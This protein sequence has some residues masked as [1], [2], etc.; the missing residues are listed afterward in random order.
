MAIVVGLTGGVGSGKTTVADL[1]QSRGAGVVDTDDISRRLT[2]AGQPA[3]KE[4]AH[5]FGAQFVTQDGAL[6]RGRMRRH[7]FADTVARRDLEAILHPLIR[8]E[9]TRQIEENHAPYVLLVVPLLIES[10]AYRDRVRR[11]LVVD[12]EVETQIRRVMAR[13]SLTR[14]EVMAIIDAQA[15]RQQRLAAADDVI[16]NDGSPDRLPPQVDKLHARYLALAA[17]G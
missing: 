11:L 8:R 3:V 10:G 15:S 7:V 14:H 9:S 1:F 4:I 12:C 13:S 5:R 16:L 6:D 2:G 17:E